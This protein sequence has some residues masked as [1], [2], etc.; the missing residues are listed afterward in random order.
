MSGY[1]AG[2]RA[3][4]ALQ[5]LCMPRLLPRPCRRP[6][7]ASLP[8]LPHPYPALARRPCRLPAVP[9]PNQIG[10]ME[11]LRHLNLS[12]GLWEG[13]LP[14]SFF[15]EGIFPNLVELDMSY[16][17]YLGGGRVVQLLPGQGAAGWVCPEE[18]SM[19]NRWRH[20]VC[21]PVVSSVFAML[22]V[23]VLVGACMPGNTPA[24]DVTS[25][26]ECP[27][28]ALTDALTTPCSAV[29]HAVLCCAG[30][31]PTSWART[32]PGIRKILLQRCQFGNNQYLAN[33][34]RVE[35]G[36]WINPRWNQLQVG[37]SGHR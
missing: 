3:V 26:I 12:F 33:G 28:H 34:T 11:N 6:A 10:F 14:A 29:R 1:L 15:R 5:N 16:S 25:Q 37:T 20:L 32:M 30:E 17:Y 18:T 23:A 27:C 36:G 19:D 21:S 7:C 2:W 8:I 4:V 9:V 22:V 24:F 31:L 13:G 35:W